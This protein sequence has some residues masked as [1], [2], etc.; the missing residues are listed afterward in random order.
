[1]RR[2]ASGSLLW[3]G[4]A[5]GLAQVGWID[6]QGGDDLERASARAVDRDGVEKLYPDAPG[7]AFGLGQED[8]NRLRHLSVD[9]GL[10]LRRGRDGNIDYWTASTYAFEYASGGTGKTARI[11]I[12][13]S[14]AAQ[15]YTW[16]AHPEYLADPLDFGSQEFTA[17]VRVRGISD[18]RHAAITL[19]IRGGEHTEREPARASCT[20]MT[21]ASTQAPAVS[22]FGKELNHPDHDY[23]ELPLR[24][25]ASLR[26]GR[27]VGLKLVSVQ[28]PDDEHRVINRLY[29][30]D[31]PFERD[32]TPRND[33]RLLSE[34][35]DREGQSTGRYDTVVNWGGSVSTLRVDGVDAL[36]VAILSARAVEPG[37]R[38]AARR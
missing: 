22:R 35:V 7:L 36:D 10:R 12:S 33:F 24:N 20:M 30:D 4:A 25:G 9:N 31:A 1:M 23:V 37:D 28:D 17:Y 26:D 21:F 32:G 16:R 11:H 15:R 13:G 34:Y 6:V 27:W 3:A 38:A 29:V 14:D 5:L 2:N 8:P 19:K 18:P